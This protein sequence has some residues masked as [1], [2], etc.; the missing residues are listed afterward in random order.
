MPTSSTIARNRSA[1]SSRSTAAL[2]ADLAEY[3]DENH[4]NLV[5]GDFA[6]S[7]FVDRFG[8]AWPT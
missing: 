4:E 3:V 1:S 2:M 5:E 7:D 8:P 6:L